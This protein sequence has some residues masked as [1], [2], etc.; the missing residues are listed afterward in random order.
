MSW[1]GRWEGNSVA[2]LGVE[3][4]DR[5]V[6]R[7]QSF[8][9]GVCTPHWRYWPENQVP[10]TARKG[11]TLI[12]YH[13]RPLLQ[14]N[15]GKGAGAKIILWIN[16]SGPQHPLSTLPPMLACCPFSHYLFAFNISGHW[17]GWL[18]QRSGKE[19]SRYAR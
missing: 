13:V 19:F 16:Y 5:G 12:C 4:R 3:G 7:L 11:E 6:R 14:N 17:H 8:S 2:A 9:A 15:S 18:P 1:A 10:V